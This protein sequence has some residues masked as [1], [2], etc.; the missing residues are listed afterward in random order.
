[1]GSRTPRFVLPLIVSVS[2]ESL[3]LT[4][5]LDTWLAYRE[6]TQTV[7]PTDRWITPDYIQ[8][9][10]IPI[11]DRQANYI[12]WI[13][14]RTVN[15]VNAFR[16]AAEEAQGAGT[17]GP[18]QAGLLQLWKETQSWLSRRPQS[19][20]PLMSVEQDPQ[21]SK[22]F[23]TIVFGSRSATTGSLLYHT[24]AMLLRE[25][26]HGSSPDGPQS[27]DED[28]AWHAIRIAGINA[29]TQDHPNWLLGLPA[30][31]IGG[32]YYIQ[33]DQ[34]IALLRHLRA[35]EIETGCITSDR[36]GALREMWGFQ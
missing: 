34:Q 28:P 3:S 19:L 2:S 11:Q 7:I 29:N 1:M 4:L 33:P 10:R 6:Q 9:D 15:A 31:Y 16:R 23:P 26:L 27:F 20:L 24:S 13:L 22:P 12:A 18:S 32:K 17:R 14:G 35:V 30:L 36:A 25:C 21:P 8:D 5:T